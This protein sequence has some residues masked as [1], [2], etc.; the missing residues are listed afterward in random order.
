MN[1]TL[2]TPLQ[3]VLL[4]GTLEAL[5]ELLIIDTLEASDHIGSS[6]SHWVL[7]WGVLNPTTPDYTG[8]HL[9]TAMNRQK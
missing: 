5:S 2:I 6:F 9:A 8:I 7:F 1:K 4:Q 3:A